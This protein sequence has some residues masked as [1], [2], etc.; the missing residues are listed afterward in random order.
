MAKN[1][2]TFM[3]LQAG[4]P[5]D[6]ERFSSSHSS[7]SHGNVSSSSLQMCAASSSSSSS[8]THSPV[9]WCC[10]LETTLWWTAWRE[11]MIKQP[12]LASE[13][14]HRHCNVT[15]SDS[16]DSN[17]LWVWFLTK[18]INSKH[19]RREL[20]TPVCRCAGADAFPCCRRAGVRQVFINEGWAQP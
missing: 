17:T 5:S 13:S 4:I 2:V 19:T 7:L 20:H 11:V 6:R 14:S 16:S 8:A 10:C 18:R 3:M 9:C 1:P 12:E 15:G